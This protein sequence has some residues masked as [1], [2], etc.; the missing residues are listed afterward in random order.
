M[1]CDRCGKEIKNHVL[2]RHRHEVG[3]IN[4]FFNVSMEQFSLCPGC[5]DKFRKWLYLYKID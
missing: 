1:N 4:C 5:A 3:F 2:I